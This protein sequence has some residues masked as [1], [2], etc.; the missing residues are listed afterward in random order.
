MCQKWTRQQLP[1]FSVRNP[2]E[3]PNRLWFICSEDRCWWWWK[4]LGSQ[5]SRDTWGVCFK[6]RLNSLLT[7]NPRISVPMKFPGD[8]QLTEPIDQLIALWCKES[9][10]VQWCVPVIPG[11]WSWGCSPW[12]QSK[13][14][15]C[16]ETL[17]QEAGGA[18]GM[19]RGRE[20]RTEG[21]KAGVSRPQI[22]FLGVSIT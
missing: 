1:T 5:G 10:R 22:V 8:S 20:G 17:S 3:E 4:G 16:S 2:G 11:F 14:E 21:R 12:F 18:G 19:G 9:N 15:L 13:S 6:G 7:P